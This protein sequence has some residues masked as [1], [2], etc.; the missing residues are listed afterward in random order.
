MI[1]IQYRGK[2]LV[3]RVNGKQLMNHQLDQKKIILKE[4][5][6][7]DESL[8]L[9]T[10]GIKQIRKNVYE[11]RRKILLACPTNL[12][13]VNLSLEK[14][15]LKTK[16]GEPFLLVNDQEKNIVIFSCTSVIKHFI[17]KRN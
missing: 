11:A 5:G 4:V 6:E 9:N 15:D 12:E 10:T 14:M 13:E 1:G 17:L 8:Q 3:Q 16:Q 7:N 2:L